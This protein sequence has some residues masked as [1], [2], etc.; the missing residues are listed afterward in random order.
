[1]SSVVSVKDVMV[2]CR[3]KPYQVDIEEVATVEI[4]SRKRDGSGSSCGAWTLKA[5]DRQRST[6]NEG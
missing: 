6:R 3:M 5:F 4:D 2:I 1:M